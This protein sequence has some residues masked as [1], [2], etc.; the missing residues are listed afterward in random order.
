VFA[1][2]ND[3][4]HSRLGVTASRKVGNAVRRNRA[5]RIVRELFRRNQ[6]LLVDNWDVVVNVHRA[7]LVQRFD[8][9]E[10]EFVRC[11]D[12]LGRVARK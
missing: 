8:H 3:L 7:M 12:R 11:S 5:K 10:R 6:A 4:G 2:P 1:L 9:L